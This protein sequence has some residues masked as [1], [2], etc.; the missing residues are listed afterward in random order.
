MF[1]K[2]FHLLLFSNH[3]VVFF[4]Q[5]VKNI[6]NNASWPAIWETRVRIPLIEKEP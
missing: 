2:K 6:S 5:N 3:I 1:T 4:F